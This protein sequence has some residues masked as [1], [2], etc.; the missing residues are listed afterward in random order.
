[1]N[2]LVNSKLYYSEIKALN[3]GIYAWLTPDDLSILK[4]QKL[5]LNAPF[6]CN[7]VTKLHL[8][9][10]HSQ[11]LVDNLY[12]ASDKVYNAFITNLTTWN[13]HNGDLIVVALL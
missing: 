2:T 11:D 8:T 4:V 12:V 9:V 10:I 13:D 3:N 5:L 6:K 1:M 7:N